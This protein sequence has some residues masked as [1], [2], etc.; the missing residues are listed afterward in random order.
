M[1]PQSAEQECRLWRNETCR[2]SCK[3]PKVRP[4]G[5]ESFEGCTKHFVNEF[6]SMAT[7]KSKE[8]KCS[9]KLKLKME[10][11]NECIYR[12]LFGSRKWQ[13]LR[14]GIATSD[15]G[16]KIS[17]GAPKVTPLISGVSEVVQN[18][19]KWFV[20]TTILA[21]YKLCSSS[22]DR[23]GGQCSSGHWEINFK[24]IFD[25]GPHS[26]KSSTRRNELAEF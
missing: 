4:W 3:V 7:S 2:N 6:N 1:L 13:N 18:G 11:R 23:L 9:Y 16:S 24:P 20:R 14:K 5:K 12:H 10:T 26:A 21:G 19:A 25:S 17:S 8:G 15:K 22:L